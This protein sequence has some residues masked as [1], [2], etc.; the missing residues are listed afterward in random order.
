[1]PKVRICNTSIELLK[2]S[3][4]ILMTLDHINT[5]ILNHCYPFLFEMGRLVMPIFTFVLAYNLARPVSKKGVHKRVVA[6]ML[7]AGCIAMP[8]FIAI[9]PAVNIWHPLNIM[10]TL[11]TSTTC[12]YFLEQG[13]IIAFFGIFLLCGALV[14]YFWPAILFTLF[15]WQ[16]CRT[17]KKGWLLL[18]LLIQFPI[19]LL[20]GTMTGALSLLI[21][22][23]VAKLKFHVEIPRCKTFFY[24]YY[25]THLAILYGIFLISF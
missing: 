23:L 17:G 7:I 2:W 22:Y 16:F 18:M 9:N 14:E 1:M 24:S 3:G 5:F 11:I 12:I 13:K 25:P 19:G 15:S 8:F 10:F 4:L 21:I 20:N 6:R